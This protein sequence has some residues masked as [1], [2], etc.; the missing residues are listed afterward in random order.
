L[1]FYDEK[2]VLNIP[3]R[4]KFL[5]KNLRNPYQG[6]KTIYELLSSKRIL[7]VG[8]LARCM[9][10]VTQDRKDGGNNKGSRK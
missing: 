9:T 3:G 1:L 10:V 6:T 4:G 8:I 2:K 7:Q 5:E